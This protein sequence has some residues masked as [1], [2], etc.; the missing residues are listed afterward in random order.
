MGTC[1]VHAVMKSTSGYLE[2]FFLVKILADGGVANFCFGK[3][4]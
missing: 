1:T 4:E 2:F 3:N